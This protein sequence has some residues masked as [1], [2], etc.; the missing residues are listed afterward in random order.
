M[1]AVQHRTSEG[2]AFNLHVKQ[3]GGFVKIDKVMNREAVVF[4]PKA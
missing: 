2:D 1:A 3:Q 4:N